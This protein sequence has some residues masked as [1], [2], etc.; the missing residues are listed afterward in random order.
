MF[1]GLI[2]LMLQAES[3]A[4]LW[5]EWLTGIF[6]AA[7]VLSFS[8]QRAGKGLTSGFRS[9]GQQVNLIYLAAFRAVEHDRILLDVNLTYI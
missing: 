2:I 8:L 9:M 4:L 5:K 1:I 7:D 3:H 6:V